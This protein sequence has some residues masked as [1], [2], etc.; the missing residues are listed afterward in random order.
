MIDWFNAVPDF[1]DLHYGN[2]HWFTFNIAD[3]FITIGV[4]IYLLKGFKKINVQNYY[5]FLILLFLSSCGGFQEAGQVLRNEK[6]KTTDE[7]LVKRDPLVLPPDYN[8]IPEPNTKSEIEKQ[9]MKKSKI[10]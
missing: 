9:K 10:Y 3:I 7:F 8:E 1:I 2:F 5:L 6:I 4:I